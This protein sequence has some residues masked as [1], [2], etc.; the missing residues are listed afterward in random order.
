MS[1]YNFPDLASFRNFLET[2]FPSYPIVTDFLDERNLTE[3]NS[4]PVVD[5]TNIPFGNHSVGWFT[6]DY[7][8][9]ILVIPEEGTF[10]LVTIWDE[11]ND[12]NRDYY[13]FSVYYVKSIEEV[14]LV[15]IAVEWIDKVALNKPVDY[16]KIVYYTPPVPLA[17]INWE[18]NYHNQQGFSR[19]WN[20]QGI[21]R[22]K[23]NG[24]TW[25]EITRLMSD[26]RTTKGWR[27]V[28]LPVGGW[29]RWETPCKYLSSFEDVIQRQSNLS[30]RLTT[31]RLLTDDL[32]IMFNRDWNG[33][34][35][36]DVFMR[37][38]G[39]NI[40]TLNFPGGLV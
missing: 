17:K 11:S 16:T 7:V 28:P 14:W 23:Y 5:F 40:Q 18:V 2:D 30:R 25:N 36:Y 3:L 37:V 13:K 34:D 33:L 32:F 15:N 39:T 35:N 27:E 29:D 4:L 10:K 26:A 8:G 20:V 12:M 9:K 24:K 19:K 22:E 31:E 21:F 38:L 1:S 6:K